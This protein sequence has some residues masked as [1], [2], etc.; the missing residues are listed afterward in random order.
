VNIYKW[1]TLVLVTIIFELV[2]HTRWQFLPNLRDKD[3]MIHKCQILTHCEAIEW[4]GIGILNIF[5]SQLV[6]EWTCHQC[7]KQFL[8][9]GGQSQ[10]TLNTEIKSSFIII[11]QSLIFYWV[12]II[13]FQF[14]IYSL[15]QL[16]FLLYRN[17]HCSSLSQINWVSLCFMKS[18]WSGQRST[19]SW[20]TSPYLKKY[21]ILYCLYYKIIWKH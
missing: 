12:F 4:P 6:T 7:D 17:P 21:S 20:E 1:N 10:L 15:I 8:W 5:W 2:S 16:T 13:K 9:G 18:K 3:S 11:C 19:A 14:S